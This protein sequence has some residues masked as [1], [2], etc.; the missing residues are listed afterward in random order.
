MEKSLINIPANYKKLTWQE[1]R[2]VRNEYV[3]RQ[4]GLCFYCGNPL[5]GSATD[6]VESKQITE[7]LFPDGFFKWPV[8]LHHDHCTDM[9]IGAVHCHCNAVLWQYHGK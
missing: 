7:H 3:K 4:K 2:W 8:H 1:R 5:S 6:S 9:T